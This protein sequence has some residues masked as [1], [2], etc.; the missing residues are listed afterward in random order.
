MICG[1]CNWKGTRPNKQGLWCN[2]DL[3]GRKQIRAT[4]SACD[5]FDEDPKALE[6]LQYGQHLELE[7]M[8]LWQLVLNQCSALTSAERLVL[9]HMRI[10]QNIK[11]LLDLMD[12][13]QVLEG[14]SLLTGPVPQLQDAHRALRQKLK[15]TSMKYPT[16][17]EV[18]G[19][20]RVQLARWSRYL[21]SPGAAA[22]GTLEFN[23]RLEE[24]G[25]I[26]ER[27]LERFEEAGGMTPEIS[28][29]IGW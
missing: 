27:I 23:E 8:R 22:I 25:K 18:E 6:L 24:E 5:C 21:N 14:T 10:S 2:C 11:R 17:E 13:C 29:E 20:D 16:P 28:K 3:S 12:K 19:A 1:L 26:L 15:E 4:D 9:F 7:N